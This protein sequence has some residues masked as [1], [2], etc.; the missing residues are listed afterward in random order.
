MKWRIYKCHM[1]LKEIDEALTAVKNCACCG[2]HYSKDT[3]PLAAQLLYH[4]R[5][6]KSKSYILLFFCCKDRLISSTR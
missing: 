6:K 4:V 3:P 5:I 2:N 1:D